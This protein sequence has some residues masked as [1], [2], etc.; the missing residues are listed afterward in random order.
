M[1][2]VITGHTSGI[3]KALYDLLIAQGHTVVGL[4]RSNGFD[5]S[6][7]LNMFMLDNWDV[8]INNAQYEFKQTE[9]L[10]KLF[11]ENK[12]RKCQIINIGSVSSDNAAYRDSINEYSTQKKAL[13]TACSQLQFSDPDCKVILVK[14]GRTDTPLVASTN[15]Y[16]IDPVYIAE[17]V[18]WIIN[19]PERILIK[20][21]TIDSLHSRRPCDV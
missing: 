14:P 9:L 21:I 10:Y 18:S 19:Q 3:G 12:N 4:S 1:K 8:Y 7:N 5:L 2:I 17:C 16:K 20:S 6:L 15:S 13:E 11:E